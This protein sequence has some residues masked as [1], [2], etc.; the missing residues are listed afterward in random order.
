MSQQIAALARETGEQFIEPDGRRV[1]LTPA[2]RR[3]ADHAVT[4]LAAVD[5]ARLDL[6]PDAEPAVAVRVSD[7]RN[8]HRVS[9]LPIVREAAVTWRHAGS[10][11]L[12]HTRTVN[13]LPDEHDVAWALAEEARTYLTIPELNS[14]FVR[15]GVGDF[16][17]AIETMLQAVA[18]TEASLSSVLVARLGQ[19]ID[20]YTGQY[21]EPRLRQYL[22]R[23]ESR[24]DQPPPSP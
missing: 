22:S 9:L 7:F 10:A 24:T 14:V 11:L 6:D 4:I 15:L 2:G 3:L 21:A 17:A 19:W 5:A 23:I 18:S 1:G 13:G 16:P 8:G 20:M 12:A